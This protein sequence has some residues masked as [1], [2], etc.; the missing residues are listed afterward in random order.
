VSRQPGPFCVVVPAYQAAPTIDAVVRGAARHVSVVLVVNDGSVDGTGDAA[1]VAGARVIDHPVNLGK[2]EALRTGLRCAYRA[3][4]RDAVTLDAD[5]QHDP[6]DIPALVAAATAHPGALVVG[7]RDMSGPSV[8]RSSR[9]GRWLTNLWVRIDGGVDVGDAQSG[10]RVYPVPEILGLG[11]QGGRFEFEMEVI[12]RAGWT[13]MPVISVPIAVRY[14]PDR[15]SHFDPWLDNARIS[16]VFAYLLVLRLVPVLRHRP[17]V[18]PWPV[19]DECR[20]PEAS[21]QCVAQRPHGGP[22]A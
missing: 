3:G 8:P 9:F 22:D 5:G 2:A 11:L 20:E 16:M 1:R 21:A 19:E 6:D 15:G 18:L 17:R 12:V 10:F 4:F 13:R 7:T 14:D